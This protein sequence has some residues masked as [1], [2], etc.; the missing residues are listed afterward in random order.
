MGGSIVGKVL[1]VAYRL[2]SLVILPWV[3]LIG[4]SG[5][6]L[7]HPAAFNAILPDPVYDEA[8]FDTWPNPVAVDE[9]GALMI[10]QA[11]LPGAQFRLRSADT[12]HNRPVYTFDA[13][14]GRV[15]VTRETGHYWV[16]TPYTRTTYD[17]SGRAL[18]HKYYW[19]DMASTL[20]ANGWL[21]DRFG[22][23]PADV[24]GVVVVIW[25]VVGF[26]LAALGRS[27]A[28][29]RRAPKAVKVKANTPRP[30]RI[31]LDR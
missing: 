29:A 12:Y 20:H 17:P 26:V 19:A 4:I 28:P 6:Y 18:E 5:I 9:Q 3:A 14:E 2:L 15:I 13:D 30:Q 8:K 21:G 22:T 1:R 24:A 10:A 11:V 27:A 16:K 7:N 25:A 23:W 31:R